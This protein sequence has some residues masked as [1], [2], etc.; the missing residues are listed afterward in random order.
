MVDISRGFPADWSYDRVVS[1]AYSDLT[2]FDTGNVFTITGE[3]L[4]RAFGVVGATQLTSTSG[5]TTLSLG[6]GGIAQ[7]II[8]N[9]TINGTTLF[10]PG[11]VWI[12]T[13]PN[14]VTDVL[15]AFSAYRSTSIT[16][17]RSVD[18]ITAGSMTIYCIWRP[19]SAGASVVAA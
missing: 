6:S 19:L 4:A 13:S 9:T 7:G 17:T 10:V 16:M 8:A 2:G 12:D 15:P 11:A 14:G 18:D 3:V 1:K 5:T